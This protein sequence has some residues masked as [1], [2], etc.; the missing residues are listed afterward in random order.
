[1]PVVEQD[2]SN[3]DQLIWSKG[4]F[5]NK[6]SEDEDLV[7]IVREDLS[8]LGFK[9]LRLIIIFFALLIVRILI[10]GMVENL[11]FIALYDFLFFS[12]NVLMVVFF[13]FL[14]HNYYLSLQIV[15]NYRIIDIDQVGLF[16][17]EV[18]EMP[19][20]SIEDVTYRQTS[21]WANLFGYGDVI[22][23]T[24]G[25]SNNKQEPS[26]FVFENVPQPAEVQACISQLYHQYKKNEQIRNAQ[27][28]AEFLQ[29]VIEKE[30]KA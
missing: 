13:A 3:Q 17:R 27:I 16:K 29:K 4:A 30:K 20:S 1:M 26:G 12:A 7:L 24:S 14:F 22:V 28:S 15:T 8:I 21:L 9:T 25:V 19:L 2:L 5:P 23:Q 10:S 18:N 11:L 6:S